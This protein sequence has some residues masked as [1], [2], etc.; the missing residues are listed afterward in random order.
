MNGWSILIV[1]LLTLVAIA[2]LIAQSYETDKKI[3]EEWK[4]TP[5]ARYARH[6]RPGDQDG[7]RR[8]EGPDEY[9]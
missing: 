4:D 9:D 7:L 3:R 2:K 1:S 6:S 8:P 5:G